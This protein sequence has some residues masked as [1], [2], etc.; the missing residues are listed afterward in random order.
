MNDRET[1]ADVLT[2]VAVKMTAR[3]WDAPAARQAEYPGGSHYVCTLT[4][5]GRSMRVRFSQGSAHRAAPTVADVLGCI[6]RDC[7]HGERFESWCSDLGLD[8][9]SRK[10]LRMFKACERTEASMRRV[11]GDA[12]VER[13]CNAEW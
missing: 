13:F 10:A 12:L 5:A 8:S 2:T 3:R 6:S 1:L 4:F 7:T 9:D 11:F